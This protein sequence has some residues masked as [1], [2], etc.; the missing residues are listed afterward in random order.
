MAKLYDLP[1]QL[2]SRYY[3]P[4]GEVIYRWAL[5]EYQMQEIIWRAMGIDNQQGRTLTVGMDAR[6]L[7]GI[8]RTL[9]RR[10]AANKTE[11]K[12]I[13]SL[14]RDTSDLYDDRNNLAHGV[15]GYPSGSKQS[16]VWLHYMKPS[17]NR[18]LP[19]A[20]KRTPRQ[21]RATANK[22]KELNQRAERL[23]NRLEKRQR[24]SPGKSSQRTRR[25]QP[26]PTQNLSAQPFQHPPSSG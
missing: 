3:A 24:T 11:T 17:K 2:P 25:G 15:W 22:I 6:V 20:E 19:R 26:T 9:I 18:I 8:F 5:L 4:I 23:I 14:A 16:D 21:I 10:W 1:L 7:T 12:M 13:S